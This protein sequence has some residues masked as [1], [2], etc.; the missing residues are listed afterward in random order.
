MVLSTKNHG[1]SFWANTGRIDVQLENGTS[2]SFFIKVTSKDIGKQM[3][4]GEFESSLEIHKLLPDFIPEPIAW[5]SYMTVPETYFFLCRFKEMKTDLPSPYDFAARLAALHQNSKSPEGKFG[6]HVDN[7]MGNIPLNNGWE[8]SWEK[9]FAKNMRHTLQLELAAQGPDI[10]FET[11]VPIL[12]EKVIPRLL[13]PLESEGRSIKPSL[14]HGDLWYAN[15]GIDVA[16]GQ[17]LVFDACCFYA[18]NECLLRF[19]LHKKLFFTNSI[20]ELGQWKPVCNRFGSEYVQAYH[21][22]VLYQIQLL[23][24]ITAAVLIYINCNMPPSPIRLDLADLG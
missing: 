6:F 8:D 15:T 14:V 16:T 18:H 24:R 7:C 11:L 17:P 2:E 13:R 23:S 10:Q 1:V 3:T 19:H 20:D 21:T 5:G 9:F 12:F 4:Q 22:Y